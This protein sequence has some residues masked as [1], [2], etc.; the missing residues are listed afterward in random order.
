MFP[1]ERRKIRSDKT[2]LFLISDQSKVRFSTNRA[3]PTV[4]TPRRI[5]RHLAVRI[6]LW[7]CFGLPILVLIFILRGCT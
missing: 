5:K 6:L 1:S 2:D 4:P 3:D 7:V